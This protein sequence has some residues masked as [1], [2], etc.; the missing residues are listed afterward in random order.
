MYRIY[1]GINIEKCVYSVIGNVR[2]H[3]QLMID[4][5][6]TESISMRRVQ[7]GGVIIWQLTLRETETGTFLEWGGPSASP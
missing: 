6:G 3:T 5:Q 1:I 4:A 2:Y 7:L